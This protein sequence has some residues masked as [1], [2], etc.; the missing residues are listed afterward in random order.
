ALD[1]QLD[2]RLT[3]NAEAVAGMAEDGSPP[4]FEYE[5]LPEVER[6]VRPGFFEA[7]LDDGRVLARSPSLGGRDL[8]RI[9]VAAGRPTLADVTLPDGRPRRGG[10]LRRCLWDDKAR[11]G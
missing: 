7:W 11:T 4:E 10:E 3:A 2:A 8:D 1:R 9:P 5:E 6:F